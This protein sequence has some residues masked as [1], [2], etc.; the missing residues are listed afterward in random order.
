MAKHRKKEKIC[1]RHYTWL[2]GQRDG[3]YY[4]DGRANRPPLGRHSLGTRDRPDADRR[5]AELDLTM[6]ARNGLVDP[7]AVRHGSGRVLALAQGRKFYED[8]AGRP[9]VT[10]GIRASSRKRY[11]AVLDK[12]LAFAE[13]LGLASWN[14]VTS[15]VLAKYAS[16][17]EREEYAYATQ[18]LELTTIKQ[19][20]SWLAANGHLPADHRVALSLKK[21]R[22]TGTYCWKPEEVRA[23]I[24]YCRA[25]PE[26]AWLA[27]VITALTYT[28]VR[29]SELASMRCSDVDTTA[30][31]VTLKDDTSSGRKKGEARTLKGGR[32]RSFPVHDEL[33]AVLESIPK[34]AD[35]LV[36]HGPNGG[37]LKP[38]TVRNVLV[39]DVLGPLAGRFPT[40]EGEVGFADGRLH[41][42]RHFFCS[43]C[44]NGGVSLSAVMKW[45][46]HRDSR[47]AQHYYHL[48][49]GEARRQMDRLTLSGG[50]GDD[51]GGK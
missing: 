15:A 45:L 48:H 29:I 42:F 46:G 32:G 36:F 37:K 24:E 38:D 4:A 19:A 40:P 7:S 1:C 34:S 39:R 5:L 2:L 11:R 31:V 12:F 44:A 41:S 30:W 18:Y 17:L 28:G 51:D 50:F 27:R 25:R 33:R 10:G 6:A 49:D 26:L 3:V 14:Q 8:H 23:M 43:M 21:P 20:T 22:G 47:M 16:H 9:R 35:G 13:T